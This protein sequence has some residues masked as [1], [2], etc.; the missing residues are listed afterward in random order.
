MFDPF[1]NAVKGPYYLVNGPW[2]GSWEGLPPDVVIMNWNHDK[3][4]ESVKFFKERGHK[5][6]AATYYDQPDTMQQTKDWVATAKGEPSIIG[7][8]YTSW[9]NDYSKMEAFADLVKGK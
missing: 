5:Q 4:A 7:F 1:H 3:R 9:R 2:T 6:I 8:M